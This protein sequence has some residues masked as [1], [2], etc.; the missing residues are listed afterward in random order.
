MPTLPEA[1]HED[2]GR[3]GRAVAVAAIIL[4]SAVSARR[5]PP[6]TC[7]VP[8]YLLFGDSLLDRAHAEV[9][10]DNA[11][12]IVSL[13]GTSSTLPGPDGASLRIRRGWKRP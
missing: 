13:G 6:T 10:K 9:A 7:A 5:N 11:L 12:K 4:C 1:R 8:G 3:P 2:V